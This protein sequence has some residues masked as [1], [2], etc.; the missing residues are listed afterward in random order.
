MTMYYHCCCSLPAFHWRISDGQGEAN[1]SIMI[2]GQGCSYST[3]FVGMV[4]G[5]SPWPFFFY[6]VIVDR[7]GQGYATNTLSPRQTTCC[8]LACKSS[9]RRRCILIANVGKS[10]LVIDRWEVESAFVAKH[11][12]SSA[13]AGLGCLVVIFWI[14]RALMIFNPLRIWWTAEF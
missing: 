2:S 14:K 5:T 7:L 1:K 8:K 4:T 12:T 9:R 10:L 6:P 13:N 11:P 3:M